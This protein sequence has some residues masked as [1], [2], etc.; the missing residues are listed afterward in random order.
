MWWG[1]EREH[2]GTG[3]PPEPQLWG[4]GGEHRARL[5][6]DGAT[7]PSPRH[8][9]R[10]GRGR[11]GRGVG[12]EGWP[13]PGGQSQPALRPRCGFENSEG[14]AGNSEAR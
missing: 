5:E 7:V 8:P 2:C 13:H 6:T 14:E 11:Q 12:K 3:P 9:I 4:E 1:G 10:R